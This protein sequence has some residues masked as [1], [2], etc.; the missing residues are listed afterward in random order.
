M[1]GRQETIRPEERIAPVRTAGVEFAYQLFG[2][3]PEGHRIA[4]W[5]K[6]DKRS[7]YYARAEDIAA[8]DGE[9]DLYISAG[10]A[11]AGLS[12]GRRVTADKVTGIPGLWADFDVNGG[13][14][15]KKHAAPTVEAAIGLAHAVREPTVLVNSGYGIQAWWLFDEPWIFGSDD[16]R[17]RAKEIAQGWHELHAA[18]AREAGIKLDSVFDLARLMRLPGTVNGKDG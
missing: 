16:E 7:F 13:P 12:T 17:Q 15:E 10:L 18:A 6:R 3:V 1:N 9:T 5:M 4:L 11:P 2:E 8:H 14:D